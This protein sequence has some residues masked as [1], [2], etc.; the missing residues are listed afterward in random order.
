GGPHIM[1]ALWSRRAQSLRI[2]R[3]VALF[4]A[5]TLT[6]CSKSDSSKESAQNREPSP[7]GTF[8]IALETLDNLD[9]AFADDAY[10]ATFITQVFSGLLRA[11]ADLNVLPDVAH[12]WTI[13]PD[14][15][16]YVFELRNDAR[17]HHGRLITAQDFIYSFTRL[18]DARRVPPGIIQDYLII[19]EGATDFIAGRADHV[20]GF[21]APDPHTLVIRLAKPYPSFLSVLC[22]DQAKVIPEEEINRRGPEAFSQDPVGSGPFRFV[23]RNTEGNWI[24]VAN[25]D[26]FGTPAFL[27][28]VIIHPLSHDGGVAQRKDFLAGKLDVMPLRQSEVSELLQHASFPI[29]R[30]LELAMEFI[31]LN[32]AKPPMKDLR[33]RQALSLALDRRAVEAAAGP[34]FLRP[35]GI[36]PPGMPGYTP[37]PKILPEDAARARALLA[38]AG[39]G[40]HHPLRFTFYATARSREGM[41]RDSVIVASWAKVGIRAERK[42]VNWSELNKA[43]EGG[44]APAFVITWIGDLPDPDTFLFTLLASDGMFNMVSFR[45][46]GLDSLLAHGR[47]ETN[48]EHRLDWYRKAE[49][50]VLAEAPIIPLFNV[51]TAYAFQPDVVGV[52]MSPYGIC[53]VPLRKVWFNKDAEGTYARF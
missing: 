14:G 22:M 35:A 42:V 45:N 44:T 47:S 36:L 23:K 31:G 8:H 51:M 40:P 13:S 20:R 5:L 37:E 18:L 25:R 43:I 33:V 46:A 19:V 32:C 28:S 49:R 16:T 3:L 12:A 53:S 34:G 17:F 11:D 6:G 26:Y 2:N 41:A 10:E 29:I 50:H 27:D 9:P 15:L 7:G 38:E 48:M 24:L 1:T 30:R 39:Y 52:E 4:A 21:S